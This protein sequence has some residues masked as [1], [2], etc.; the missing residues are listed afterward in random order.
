MDAKTLVAKRLAERRWKQLQKYATEP[1]LI[2][3]QQ[4]RTITK[5]LAMT[6]YGQEHGVTGRT[7][8]SMYAK[9]L[10]IVRYEDLAPYI[11]RMLT[12]ERRVLTAERTSWFAKSS[13][14]TNAKSKYI[15]VNNEHLRKCH[16][17]GGADSIAIYLHHHP[18]SHFF[19][20][21]AFAL[22]GSYDRVTPDRRIRTGDLSAVLLMKM[23]RFARSVRVPSIDAVLHPEWEQKLDLVTNELIGQDIGNIS[24]V[25]SWMML[26][27]REVLRKT[28]AQ[29]IKEVWPN[30]ELFFHGGIAF[31]PYRSEYQQLIGADINYEETYNASE[32]FFGIQSDPQDSSLLLM[33]DYGVYYE[34]IPMDRFDE[35]DLSGAI[36]LHK[37]EEGKNY[38]II[39]STLGGLYRYLLG[40]TV[41]FTSVRPYKFLITGRTKSFINAFGEELM[42]NNAD[43][44][45]HRLGDEMGI[46]ISEYTAGPVFMVEESKGYHH[47]VVEWKKV[48][49]DLNHFTR[50]FD[51]VLQELN[52]DYEAKRYKDLSLQMPKVSVVPEG[53]FYEW[54]K[55]RNKLGGQNKVPRL[56][57]DD[58]FVKQLLE[59]ADER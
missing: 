22:A 39:I 9:Q 25:P 2:Q 3:A 31:T 19:A 12:G 10:P 36:P 29:N 14:T 5:R 16:Y 45:F 13:G 26:V 24:G 49:E 53:T 44:A 59:I 20:H 46:A 7:G 52:S 21:K 50:R 32:G 18:E 47:W 4:L 17:R 38:A 6:Q 37:V 55:R 28:G 27:L 54:M 51:E 42:V 43:A 34:F 56:S 30:L 11:E 40:D 48:P 33:L 58:T 57:K 41:S 35:E 15:P 23:P 1:D 8:R